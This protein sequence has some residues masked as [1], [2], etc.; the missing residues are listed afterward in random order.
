MADWN[1]AHPVAP[2]IP[3]E[4]QTMAED[5]RIQQLLDQNA[6]ITQALIDFRHGRFEGADGMDGKIV[7]LNG[8]VLPDGWAPSYPPLA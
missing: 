3:Q 8:G 4:E 5:P 6:I 1:R 7:A 2:A